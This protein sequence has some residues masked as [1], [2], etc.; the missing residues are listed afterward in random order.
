MPYIWQRDRA[1]EHGCLILFM[2]RLHEDV[3]STHWLG[4]TSWLNGSMPKKRGINY[5]LGCGLGST[6]GRATDWRQAR[7]GKER[8]RPPSCAFR[9]SRAPSRSDDFE[10]C[11][12]STYDKVSLQANVIGERW[13]L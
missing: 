5:S 13:K 11:H 1:S 12:R 8:S 6:R 7:C 2:Q 9:S 10:P 4:A 3:H